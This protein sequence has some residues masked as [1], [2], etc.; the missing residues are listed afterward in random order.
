MMILLLLLLGAFVCTGF[1]FDKDH[2][3]YGATHHIRMSKTPDFVE[4]SPK[5][6]SNVTTL[7]KRG[8]RVVIFD[9]KY[10]MTGAYFTIYRLTQKDSGRYIMRDTDL[11]ELSSYTLEVTART[12][13][14]R[15][16]PGGSFRVTFNLEPNSCNIY[17]FPENVRQPRNLNGIVR[18]GRLQGGLDELDCVGFGRLEPCGISNKA[19]QMSCNGRYEIRDEN[20]NTALVVSLEMEK[21]TR[22]IEHKPGENFN[23]NLNLEQK[24][25]NIYF[26]PES[27]RQ[28][29][30]SVIN[31][32]HQGRLE[33]RLDELDCTGFY[34]L[35]PCG[36][37]NDDLQ[38]SCSGRYE[39]R[40]Q[41]DNTASVVSLEMEQLPYEPS[42]IGIGF[43]VF[44]APFFF[45]CVKFCCCGKST[46]KEDRTETAAADPDAQ[47]QEYDNEPDGARS[48]QL[49]QPS[50]VQHP[51]QP[52]FTPAGPLVHDYPS[53]SLPPAYSEIFSSPVEQPDAP[54]VPVYSDPEPKFEMKGVTFPSAPP[55]SSDSTY[56]DVYTSEKLNFL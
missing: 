53:V 34:L 21:I 51:A 52:S 13:A 40:D 39:I 49:I 35:N 33:E 41:N 50:G 24:Y 19:L 36:I 14:S 20:N 9:R 15:E 47:Y 7:W 2:G 26:F 29:R 25:C 42:H 23:F 6:N 8:D 43:G 28:S 10:I 12:R 30:G 46:S 55:L 48:D 17:F 11:K 37:A 31:I 45:C 32:V 38:I 54:S 5:Y 56:C 16:K 1:L 44:L 22:T 3:E 18:Q 27:D 4:F